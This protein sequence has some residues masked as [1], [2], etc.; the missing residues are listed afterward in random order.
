MGCQAA[1]PLAACGCWN[2]EKITA[3]SASSHPT[4]NL[5]QIAVKFDSDWARSDFL[6]KKIKPTDFCLVFFF[7][8]NRLEPNLES[9]LTFYRQLFLPLLLLLPARQHQLFRRCG[10]LPHSH[11]NAPTLLVQ[12][13][14][15]T[16]CASML[17]LSCAHVTQAAP[18]PHHRH[19]APLLT[20]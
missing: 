7:L 11:L 1:R 6:T 10:Q 8:S 16:R 5:N 20:H 2:R 12:L 9:R 13:V 3:T 4:S 14:S 17:S 19:P 15:D 18:P